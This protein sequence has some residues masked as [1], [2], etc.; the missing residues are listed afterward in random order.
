MVSGAFK[1]V[2][3]IVIFFAVGIVLNPALVA[4]FNGFRL[5]GIGV[6][7]SQLLGAGLVVAAK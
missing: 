5:P 3:A 1:F 2:F 4:L 7:I 6:F